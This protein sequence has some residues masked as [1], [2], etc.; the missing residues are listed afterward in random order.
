MRA[1][2]WALPAVIAS[3]P[4]RD[5]INLPGS[6]ARQVRRF[7]RNDTSVIGIVSLLPNSC[8]NSDGAPQCALHHCPPN[9]HGGASQATISLERL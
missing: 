6:M 2:C 9:V 5:S 7:G 8:R 4:V 1:L 3:L